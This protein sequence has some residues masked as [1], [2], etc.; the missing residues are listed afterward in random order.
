MTPELIE[1]L[2]SCAEDYWGDLA[3]EAATQ[4]TAD[5]ARIAELEAKLAERTAE[6]VALTAA[7]KEQHEWHCR[8]TDPDPTY[9][10]I[11]ADEYGDS[12]MYERTMKA[13]NYFPNDGEPVNECATTIRAA[14]EQGNG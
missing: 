6:I 10:F 9:G 8:Q 14:K 4:G 5:N 12:R 13:L 1:R 3:C 2:Q 11:P 7:L